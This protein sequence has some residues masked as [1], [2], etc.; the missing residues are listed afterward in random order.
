LGV[1]GHAGPVEPERAFREEGAHPGVL[2]K[3]LGRGVGVG[4]DVQEDERSRVGDHLDREGGA[5]HAARPAEAQDRGGHPRAGVTG[6]DHGVGPAALHQ[7]A[8]DEDRGILLLAERERRMLV[9]LDDLAGGLDRHVGRKGDP[10]HGRD[11]LGHADEDHLVVGI[12]GGVEEGARHDL[13]GGVV[14][15]HRVDRQADPAAVLDAPDGCEVHGV[16]L[17]AAA[18]R[19]TVRR[20]PRR[21]SS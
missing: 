4:P 3:V 12:L 16:R 7:V 20:P 18:A 1:A 9:H 5:I 17:L 8:G 14:S 13:F 15:A 19:A 11:P 10:G 6:G 2:G 21:P